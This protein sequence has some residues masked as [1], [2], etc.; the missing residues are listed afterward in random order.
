MSD[1]KLLILELAEFIKGNRGDSDGY[2]ASFFIRVGGSG[3]CCLDALDAHA[4]MKLWALREHRIHYDN[5]RKKRMYN[6]YVTG[7]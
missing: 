5:P 6:F 2:L 7:T 1:S 4:Y 3:Y